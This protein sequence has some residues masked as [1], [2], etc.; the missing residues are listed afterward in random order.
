M[1][2]MRSP[3]PHPANRSGRAYR[4]QLLPANEAGAAPLLA[5]IVRHGRRGCGEYRLGHI[6]NLSGSATDSGVLQAMA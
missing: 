3:S 2:S 5:A 1:S 6:R 4:F